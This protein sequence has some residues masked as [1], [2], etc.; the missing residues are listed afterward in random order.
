MVLSCVLYYLIDSYV[1]IHYLQCQ[2][3]TLRTISSNKIFEQTSFNILPVIG[4]PELLLNLLS[5]HGFMEKPNTIVVLNCRS[6]FMNTNL[7]TDFFIIKKDSKQLSPLPND[8]KLRIFVIDKLEA[9]FV[10]KKIKFLCSKHHKEISHTV[11]FEFYLQ[12]RLL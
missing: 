8:V 2:P 6:H 1:C 11:L 10:M 12:T 5:C 4:I 7:E 9:Y 3:K